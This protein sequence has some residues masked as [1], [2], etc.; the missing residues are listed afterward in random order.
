LTGAEFMGPL[1]PGWSRAKIHRYAFF[2]H[3]GLMVTEGILGF[4]STDA[5]GRGDH[6]T[7]TGLL[8]VHA[9]IGIAIPLTILGAGA[10]MGPG[11]GP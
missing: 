5:L 9:G 2:L 11:T 7:F 4:L 8:A 6:E 1:P 10:I 3:A